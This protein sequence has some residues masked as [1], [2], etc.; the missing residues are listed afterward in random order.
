[1]VN[2]CSYRLISKSF[3]SRLVLPVIFIRGKVA[4]MLMCLLVFEIYDK[5]Q[6]PIHGTEYKYLS[7]FVLVFYYLH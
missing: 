6:H 2:Y 3:P 1:M 4:G 7:T 5:T